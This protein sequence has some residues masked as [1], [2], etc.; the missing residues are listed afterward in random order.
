MGVA[1]ARK[2]PSKARA[3]LVREEVPHAIKRIEFRIHNEPYFRLKCGEEELLEMHQSEWSRDLQRAER[4]STGYGWLL[5]KVYAR[6]EPGLIGKDSL[7]QAD[8]VAALVMAIRDGIAFGLFVT[9]DQALM[10]FYQKAEQIAE[11]DSQEE[12]LF[13]EQTLKSYEAHYGTI[14]EL[15]T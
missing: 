5:G 15:Y 7:D 14:K 10:G 3:I 4:E 13:V 8:L 12:A 1:F 9:N 11:H 2:Y 6:F